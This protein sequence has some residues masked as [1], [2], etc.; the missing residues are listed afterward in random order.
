MLSFPGCDQMVT[1]SSMCGVFVCVFAF[2]LSVVFYFVTSLAARHLRPID[3]ICASTTRSH[4]YTTE[5]TSHPNGFEAVA[6]IVE[7]ITKVAG[8]AR[9]QAS[10]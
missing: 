3:S 6:N 5:S 4:A 8:I 10:G 2:V 1:T 9:A 7:S